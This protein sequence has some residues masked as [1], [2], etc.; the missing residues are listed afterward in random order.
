MAKTTASA[1]GTNRYR[2]TPDNRNM[3]ANTMQIDSVDT[4]A[5]VAI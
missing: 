1:S 3:G 5:G 4:N 2:A